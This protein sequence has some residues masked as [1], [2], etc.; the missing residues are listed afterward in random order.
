MLKRSVLQSLNRTITTLIDT[1]L[2]RLQVELYKT[3]KKD[4]I[5]IRTLRA[6]LSK[7]SD[8]A[9][10]VK[11]RK[12]PHLLGEVSGLTLQNE[13]LAAVEATSV[14]DIVAPI[15]PPNYEDARRE[16]PGATVKRFDSF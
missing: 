5:P 10:M 4:N 15:T 6:A 1:H 14:C 16:H 13:F 12:H 11:V 8:L 7:F 9:H 2:G 3:I